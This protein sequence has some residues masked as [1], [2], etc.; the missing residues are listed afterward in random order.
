MNVGHGQGWLMPRHGPL[1]KPIRPHLRRVD[2]VDVPLVR[3][4]DAALAHMPLRPHVVSVADSRLMPLAGAAQ[5]CRPEKAR[6]LA[7]AATARPSRT[8]ASIYSSRVKL[9]RMSKRPEAAPAMLDRWLRIGDPGIRTAPISGNSW[10]KAHCKRL[11]VIA[12][13]SFT[14]A[15]TRLMAT[16]WT[17]RC[18]RLDQGLQRRP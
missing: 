5:L 12:N 6:P 8:S 16:A 14:R 3:T 13:R 1:G 18:S 7:Q 4:E 9:S 10:R 17:S 15:R 11:R 2:P